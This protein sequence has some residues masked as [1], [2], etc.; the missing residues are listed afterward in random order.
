VA[1]HVASLV[2]ELRRQGRSVRAV[3]AAASEL[4]YR[5]SRSAV[6]RVVGPPPRRTRRA[7]R[8]ADARLAAAAIRLAGDRDAALVLLEQAAARLAAP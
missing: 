1:P 3:V 2:R 7:P 4:G 6:G 8:P 5:V